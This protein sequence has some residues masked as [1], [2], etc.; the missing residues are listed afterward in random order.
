MKYEDIGLICL[1]LVALL[2]LLMPAPD[3]VSSDEM[4]PPARPIA[5]PKAD[6]PGLSIDRT[7]AHGGVATPAQEFLFEVGWHTDR[8]EVY[9]YDKEQRRVPLKEG[10]GRVQVQFA[11]RS[12]VPIRGDLAYAAGADAEHL[13]ADLDLARIAEG[14]AEGT[15]RLTHLPGREEREVE[16]SQPFRIARIVHWVCGRCNEIADQPGA[17][18][19]CKAE[20]VR[21]RT[22]YGCPVHPGVASDRKS[23]TC[24]KCGGKKLYL[25]EETEQPVRKG[26]G[27]RPE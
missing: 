25:M 17:C 22:Y 11:D 8:V 16:F 18:P 4:A 9:V 2:L 15:F 27:E 13:E 20:L 19:K 7:Q 21:Q 12:R 23:D 26:T 24:W 6:V 10:R 14:E 3:R 5:G 1:G